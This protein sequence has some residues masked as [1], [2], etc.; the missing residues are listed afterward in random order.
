VRPID[1]LKKLIKNPE[2]LQNC[3]S[4]REACS[5]LQISPEIFRQY[6]EEHQIRHVDLPLLPGKSYLIKKFF[7][8]YYQIHDIQRLREIINIKPAS[9]DGSASNRNFFNDQQSIE[10]NLKGLDMENSNE[11]FSELEKLKKDNKSLK[12]S[13]KTLEAE[14]KNLQKENDTLKK[15]KALN[16]RANWERSLN[17]LVRYALKIGFGEIIYSES[18]GITE[19]NSKKLP[20]R[21][22]SAK[23]K[24]FIGTN[25]EILSDALDAFFT[26][27][28]ELNLLNLSGRPKRKTAPDAPKKSE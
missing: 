12:E 10:S 15:K 22:P 18:D 23:L 11:L 28:T 1:E 2:I 6:I 4:E 19:K 21:L 16:S 20:P 14:N 8:K 5:K 25:N 24:N 7:E 26:V 9:A 17:I 13:V 3:M 27:L